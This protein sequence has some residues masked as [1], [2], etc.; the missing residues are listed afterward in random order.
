MIDPGDIRWLAGLLE[1]EGCFLYKSTP[2][3]VLKMKDKDVVEHAANLLGGRGVRLGAP[4]V[5]PQW[6]QQ[7]SC[8]VYGARAAGWMMTLYGLMGMRRKDKIR[9]VLAKWKVA[10]RGLPIGK[11]HFRAGTLV[12][13][14]PGGHD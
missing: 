3:I 1:G 4:P 11:Y 5:K 7:Y 14:N 12:R 9:E 6:N 10:K 2:S 13:V 8:A